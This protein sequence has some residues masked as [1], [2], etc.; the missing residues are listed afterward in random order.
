MMRD[1]SMMKHCPRCGA[2]MP[3]GATIC[4][5]CGYTLSDNR[6]RIH[7]RH[8]GASVP[9]H[10]LICPVCGH[11]LQRRRLPWRVDWRSAVVVL[12]A[13]LLA[14]FFWRGQSFLMATSLPSWPLH[15]DRQAVELSGSPVVM[16][17]LPSATPT[18]VAPTALPV[19]SVTITPYSPPTQVPRPTPLQ[20]TIPYVV[21]KGDTPENIAR[22][23]E[24]SL[25]ALLAANG[26]KADAVIHVGD[27][28]VV[29]L[30][31]AT[32]TATPSPT[33]TPSPAA[34]LTSIPS[35]T[36]IVTP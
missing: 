33:I 23:W 30:P 6:K 25:A 35:P 29:P 22:Q 2:D 21:Q 36:V 8:C 10:L 15:V 12:L 14:I 9:A 20:H 19:P 28:L 18:P 3:A 16:L 11:S 5:K 26:L 32:P 4:P 31:T 7:C 17:L 27:K 34:N 1:N 13:V 24:T